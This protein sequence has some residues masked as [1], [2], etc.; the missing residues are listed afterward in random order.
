MKRII[1]TTL[2]ACVALQSNLLFAHF[3]WLSPAHSGGSGTVS[4]YFGEAATDGDA[5]YL[6]RVSDVVVSRIT[7]TEA[8]QPLTLQKSKQSISTTVDFSDASVYITSHDLGIME[9]SGTAFQLKYYAK[10]GPHSKSATWKSAVSQDDL[11]LDIQPRHDAGQ[12][13]VT[14]RFDEEP[15]V[16]AQLSAMG[17]NLESFEVETDKHGQAKIPASNQGLYSIR[18]RHVEPGAGKLKEEAFDETRHYSTLSLMVS[19]NSAVQ[20]AVTFQDIPAAVTSFG[21]AVVDNSLYMYG[22]HTGSAHSYSTKEQ[23]NQLTR[24]NLQSGKWDTVIEGPHL[25]GLALVAHGGKLY[26]IGGFTALNAEGEEHDLLSQNLVASYNPAEGKW[27]EL[28]ALP[29]R[30]SS[31]DAAVVGD[32]IYVAGGW[33]MQDGESTWHSTAWKLDLKGQPLHWQPVKSPGFQRRA[34]AIAAHNG[35]LYVIG[36][37]QEKGGPT[38]ATSVYDPSSDSWSEGPS[39]AVKQADGDKE[40]GEGSGRSMSSGAMTGFGASAF[41]T[42]G[43]LY[44]TTVQGDVQRLSDDGSQWE[45]LGQSVS[46]RFFHR[47]LPLSDKQLI[48]VGGANMGI[49]KFEEVE[50]I[51]ISGGE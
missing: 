30:R 24:L 19:D 44:V 50:V 48:V 21:A 3:I 31:H 38:T 26:R 8:A 17:P 27:E 22:G 40:R 41:A 49:G 14:V 5:E 6:N 39:L 42:G 34:I 20:T 13:V 12:I 1:F 15:V 4:V 11:R 51:D 2:A 36:G 47:L 43:H 45:A 10:T 7:G 33:A 9:R 16:A 29:E 25:Q 46:P 37:M 18:A 28:P 32:T 35:K 23:S